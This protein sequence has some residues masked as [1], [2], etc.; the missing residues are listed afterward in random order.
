MKKASGLWHYRLEAYWCLP[1][2]MVNIHRPGEK[3]RNGSG[4]GS[5]TCHPEA[6]AV[7]TEA[8]EAKMDFLV[9]ADAKILDLYEGTKEAEI[10]TI[11]KYLQTR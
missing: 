5:R 7:T 1:G 2:Y 4:I 10:M 11:G 9:P 8:K 6:T 3:A